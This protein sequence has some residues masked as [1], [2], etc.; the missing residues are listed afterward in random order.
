MNRGDKVIVMLYGG[1]TAERRVIADKGNVVVI[2][3]ESEYSNARAE[4][5]EPEGIGFPRIDV[6]DSEVTQKKPATCQPPH[7]HQRVNS[8]D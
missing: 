3:H 1:G 4:G 5:R 8:G 2:C 7:G 6:V